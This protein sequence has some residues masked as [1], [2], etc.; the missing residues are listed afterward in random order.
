MLVLTGVLVSGGA[1]SVALLAAPQFLPQTVSPIWVALSVMAGPVYVL[2]LSPLVALLI[3]QAISNQR[4][5]L[6]DADAVRL[7]RDPEGLA[8]ALVKVS[9]AQPV[10]LAVGEGCAHLYFVDPIQTEPSL[11][12]TLFPSH[13][14]LRERIELLAGMGSV[15]PSAL[16][17]ASAAGRK[18]R[19]SPSENVDVDPVSGLKLLE[20]S[21]TP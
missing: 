21:G 9:A 5:F 7:T 12:H 14:A 2:L 11:L 3:R 18:S 17:A 15:D 20:R 4:E 8:L 6:A 1:T 13:P 19:L 10:P 16:K